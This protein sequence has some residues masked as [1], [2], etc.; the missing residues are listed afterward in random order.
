M[1]THEHH[2]HGKKEHS[3][4]HAAAQTHGKTTA[5]EHVFHGKKEHST[6]YAAASF[7]M[8]GAAARVEAIRAAKKKKS[9]H[10]SPSPLPVP[11]APPAVL[12]EEVT[13][14]HEHEAEVQAHE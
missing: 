11:E 3:T 5:H 13:E 4:N 9:Q 12:G 2:F 7:L 1:T 6:T 8:P 14:D 10:V